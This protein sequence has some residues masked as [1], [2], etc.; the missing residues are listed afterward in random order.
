MTTDELHSA[1]LE[2]HMLAAITS[3]KVK[4]AL[5]QRLG[6]TKTGISGLQYG[7]MRALSCHELTIS[8]LSHRFMLDPSTLV[9]AVDAL[10]RKGFATRGSD[11][12]D[13]RRV[14]LSLTERGAALVADTPVVDDSDP[15]VQSLDALEDEQRHQLLTLLR[16]LV[17][18]M[19]E[20]EEIL[21][22]VSARVRLHLEN[23]I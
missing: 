21:R 17:R 12:N 9:P 11:P 16:E 15:L 22:R 8:E 1:A 5:E 4:H 2:I 18:H 13:R 7:I 19:P 23:M 14:P 3:K 20:G 10:E 6:L